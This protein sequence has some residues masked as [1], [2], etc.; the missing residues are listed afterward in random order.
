[1]EKETLAKRIRHTHIN[2]EGNRLSDTSG[3]EKLKSFSPS[4]TQ[5][6]LD[7]EIPIMRIT[8]YI[9]S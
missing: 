5:Y 3:V 1:M 8:N 7:R 2:A 6:E 4:V 9:Y